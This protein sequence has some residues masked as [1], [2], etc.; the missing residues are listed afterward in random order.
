MKPCIFSILD[1]INHFQDFKALMAV[2]KK[3]IT[4][5]AQIK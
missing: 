1:A 5:N 3:K 4:A 2:H